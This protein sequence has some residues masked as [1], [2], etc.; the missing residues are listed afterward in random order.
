MFQEGYDLRFGAAM[1]IPVIFNELFLRAIWAI[2]RHFYHELPWK[3]CMPSLK[4]PGLNKMLLLGNAGLCLIDGVHAGVKSY[5][6]VVMLL[7]S[8]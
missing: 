8:F 3:D 6:K 5:E 1:S 2:K 4:N 7:H